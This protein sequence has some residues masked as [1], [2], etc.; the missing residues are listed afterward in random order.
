MSDNIIWLLEQWGVWSRLDGTDKLS[1][2]SSAMF[3]GL[4]A[5]RPSVCLM[6]ADD[7][8]MVLDNVICKLKQ[9]NPDAYTVII[10]RYY[11]N[12]TMGTISKRLDSGRPKIQALEEVGRTYIETTLENATIIIKPKRKRKKAINPHQLKLF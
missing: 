11:Y 6:I 4:V 8:A 5:P 7:K 9:K 3:K 12:M 2:C 1:H 10:M